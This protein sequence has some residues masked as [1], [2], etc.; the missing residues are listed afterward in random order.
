MHTKRHA[1]GLFQWA[2]TPVWHCPTQLVLNIPSCLSLNLC[3][4]DRVKKKCQHQTVQPSHEARSQGSHT[5]GEPRLFH[6]AKM[7]HEEETMVHKSVDL[8]VWPQQWGKGIPSECTVAKCYIA[9]PWWDKWD[10]PQLKSRN[11]VRWLYI[12]EFPHLTTRRYEVHKFAFTKGAK[13]RW[14]LNHIF[15]PAWKN[16][17]EFFGI[18]CQSRLWWT[19]TVEKLPDRNTRKETRPSSTTIHQS[20]SVP[21][22]PI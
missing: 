10:K 1:H 6:D 5:G 4:F 14:S 7:E 21:S 16:L 19:W 15:L 12:H 3:A 2:N 13:I 11:C 9:V 8:G 18:S 20:H 22:N 17:T